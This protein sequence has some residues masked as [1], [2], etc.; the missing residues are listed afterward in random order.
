[1]PDCLNHER[2]GAQGTRRV[3]ATAVACDECAPRILA[4]RREAFTTPDP[5]PRRWEA[6]RDMPIPD[7]ERPVAASDPQIST[8]GTMGAFEAA[9]WRIADILDVEL[10]AVRGGSPEVV[11][12]AVEEL[13]EERDAYRAIVRGRF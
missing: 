1:M 10:K 11:I 4:E 9:L 12:R 6:A 7:A 13:V 5:T 3:G 2:C 8:R